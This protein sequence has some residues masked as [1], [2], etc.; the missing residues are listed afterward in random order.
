MLEALF[1]IE[2]LDLRRNKN[3]QVVERKAGA[4]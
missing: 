2:I 1:R 3:L 4:G